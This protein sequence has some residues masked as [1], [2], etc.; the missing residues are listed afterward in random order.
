MPDTR[1]TITIR[2]NPVEVIRVPYFPQSPTD[3]FCYVCSLK[4]VLAYFKNVYPDQL[5]NS[6]TPELSFDEIKKITRT[7][8]GGTRTETLIRDLQ[9]NISTL[10]FKIVKDGNY[11]MIKESLDLDIPV[12]VLYCGSFLKYREIA[13][14]HAGVVIGITDNDIILNNPWFGY[15]YVC[16]KSEFQDAWDIER[17]QFI[18]IKPRSQRRLDMGTTGV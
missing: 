16:D 17:N 8:E 4:M 18:K 15:Q 10:E 1:L 6:N 9:E 12:I 11:N 7:H 5:I 13:G 14:G 2:D 3:N